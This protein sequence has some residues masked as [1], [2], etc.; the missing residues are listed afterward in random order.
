M[1]QS[2]FVRHRSGIW[3]AVP[4]HPTVVF[5]VSCGLGPVSVATSLLGLLHAESMTKT[6]RALQGSGGVLSPCCHSYLPG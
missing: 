6:W 3:G 1:E 2:S 4:P 5:T